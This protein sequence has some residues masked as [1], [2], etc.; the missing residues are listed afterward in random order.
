MKLKEGQIAIDFT[1]TDIHGKEVKLSDYKGKK[2]IL[3]FMRNVSCPFCNVRVHR[4]MGTSVALEHSGVQMVLLFESSAEK[5]KSSVLH[6]GILPWPIIGDPE[7]KMYKTYRIENSA[8]KMMRTM[9]TKDMM[10]TMKLGKTIETT[11]EKDKDSSDT[12]IPADFFINENFVIERAHY[13]KHLGDHIELDELKKF[14][15]IR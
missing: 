4:L 14:A 7:K 11:K 12:L 8:L 2:I 15:G 13:G 9:F 10:G 1:T 6:K 3:T 5:L